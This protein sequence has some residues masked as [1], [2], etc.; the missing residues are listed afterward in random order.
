MRH[1]AAGSLDRLI[2]HLCDGDSGHPMTAELSSMLA[3]SSRFAAFAEAHRE[4]IRK[5]LRTAGD[6]EALNGVRAELRVARLLLGDPRIDLAFEE[7]GTSGGPDFT[8]RY[9]GGQPIACEVTRMRRPASEVHDAGPVLTKLRQLRPSIPNV[10]IIAIGGRRPDELDVES[11]VRWLRR[12][13]D[14]KDESFFTRHGFAGTRDFYARFLRLSAV[15]AWCEAASGEAGA[16]PWTNRSA[17]I[18][19]PERA[20]RAVVAALR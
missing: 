8:V 2:D 17:H 10:L 12:R 20:L 14:T 18:A 15:I 4:K 7:G 1:T 13:A 5:K 6:A 19:V 11:G 3:G 9:R 16:S